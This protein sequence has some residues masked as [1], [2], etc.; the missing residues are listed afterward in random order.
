MKVK[1]DMTARTRKK[2][3]LKSFFWSEEIC[4]NH[5]EYK[6]RANQLFEKKWICT[7]KG[8]Y[9]YMKFFPNVILF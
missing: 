6:K 9:I 2:N 7:H 8:K 3:Q 4:N 1:L 5:E